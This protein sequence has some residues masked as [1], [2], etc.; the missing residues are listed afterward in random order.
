MLILRV[1]IRILY[2]ILLVVFFSHF[3]YLEPRYSRWRHADYN[4]PHFN[5]FIFIFQC[6]W[7]RR[8]VHYRFIRICNILTA[9]CERYTYKNFIKLFSLFTLCL[10]ST[11][12]EK[13]FVS[14]FGNS[15]TECVFWITIQLMFPL[16][17]L[18]II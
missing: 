15:S 2:K 18:V 3:L 17:S 13:N 11:F 16:K 5:W 14:V 7:I 4:T 10:P 1:E 12:T 9:T 6:D 8:N